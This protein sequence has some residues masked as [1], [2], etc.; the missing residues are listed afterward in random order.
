MKNE[1][2]TAVEMCFFCLSVRLVSLTSHIISFKLS[3]TV[4]L[5]LFDGVLM[6]AF[7]C[8]LLIFLTFRL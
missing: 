7:V 6:N 5:F 3:Y 2:L 8:F 1:F 4:D